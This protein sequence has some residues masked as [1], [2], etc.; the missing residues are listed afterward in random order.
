MRQ[1]Q[2]VNASAASGASAVKK[3]MLR[4]SQKVSS[5]SASAASVASAES[6]ESAESVE[7]AESAK[8]QKVRGAA[9]ISD[10]VLIPGPV[11]ILL[12]LL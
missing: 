8:R 2:K 11:Q 10:V 5:I 3:W 12:K 7:S 4:Q 1:S 6:A 9:H